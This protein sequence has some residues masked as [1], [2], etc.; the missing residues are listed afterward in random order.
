MKLGYNELGY[1]EHSVITNRFLHKIGYF[2]TQINL[3]ITSPGNNELFLIAEFDCN[4]IANFTGH[5]YPGRI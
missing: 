2:S 3:V 1:N 4:Y 5:G